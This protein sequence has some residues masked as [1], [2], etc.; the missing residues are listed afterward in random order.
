M[1]MH[2]TRY[3]FASKNEKVFQEKLSTLK[4]TG[5]KWMENT[6]KKEHKRYMWYDE[7]V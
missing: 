1:E 3:G 5:I 4:Y 7:K 2:N 6:N